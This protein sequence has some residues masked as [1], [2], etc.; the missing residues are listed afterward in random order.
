MNFKKTVLIILAAFVTLPGFAQHKITMSSGVIEFREIMEIEVEGYDGNEVILG[1]SSDYKIPERAKGLR[2]VNG[3]GLKDNTGVGLAVED[4]SS[5]HKVIY[6]VSRNSDAKYKVKVPKGVIVKYINSSIHGED[7]LAK[8]ISNEIEVKTH[9]GNIKL[10]DVTGPLSANSVHGDIEVTFTSVNQKLPVSVASVHGDVDVAVPG[11][12]DADLSI[13][14]SWGEVYSD[15]DI[16]VERHD[17]MK[18]YGA[19][20]IEGKL[21]AGGVDMAIS[22]THGN[23]YLRKK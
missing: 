4:E 8:N 11:G 1:T 19:K 22:S 15:L 16:K 10:Q 18:V 7:F 14:T 5:D 3:M 12:T 6:Q 2:P 13:K 23:V 9:G 17:G 21:N 20:K